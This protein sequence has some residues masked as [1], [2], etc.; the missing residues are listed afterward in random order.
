M[1]EQNLDP[2][3]DAPDRDDSSSRASTSDDPDF[4]RP[5]SPQAGRLGNVDCDKLCVTLE[6]DFSKLCLDT[7]VL[8]VAYIDVNVNGKDAGI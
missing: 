7:V 6:D 5:P 4:D 2:Y 1:R 8:R 3:V